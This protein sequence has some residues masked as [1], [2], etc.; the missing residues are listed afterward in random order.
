MKIH[1][2][3]SILIKNGKDNENQILNYDYLKCIKC[4]LLIGCLID[5]NF[6]FLKSKIKVKKEKEISCNLISLKEDLLNIL[7]DKINEIVKKTNLNISIFKN[8]IFKN[9]LDKFSSYTKKQF[10]ITLIIHK[11][12]GR[13]FLLGKNGYYNKVIEVLNLK[14]TN[15]IYFILLVKEHNENENK[16]MILELINNGDEKELKP[17]YEN[18]KIIFLDNYDLSNDINKKEKLFLNLFEDIYYN[19]KSNLNNNKLEEKCEIEK[20]EQYNKDKNTIDDFA[21]YIVNGQSIFG[22]CF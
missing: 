5:D 11:I 14:Y 9:N 20:E 13:V 15:N 21:N 4:K 22:K 16:K 6:Y 10:D 1:S 2:K 19:I 18:N 3:N 12:E 8:Q 7:N 17:F